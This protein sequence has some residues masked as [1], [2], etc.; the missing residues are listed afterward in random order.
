MNE[1][2]VVAD[3][4]GSMYAAGKPA[5]LS[6][7]IQTISALGKSDDTAK[8]ITVTKMQWDG[9]RESFELLAEKCSGK[10]ML[11]L[12]DGYSFLDNCRESQTIKKFLE[13]NRENVFVI[14]CGGDA[15]DI[16]ISV[17]P[18]LKQHTIKV[19]NILFA[20]ESLFFKSTGTDLETEKESWE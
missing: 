15:V 13:T 17:F 9:N 18:M 8:D 5:I 11:I 16:S 10:K 2:I 20:L 14:L 1:L 12:T 7:I 19:E 4:S 6:N 3:V